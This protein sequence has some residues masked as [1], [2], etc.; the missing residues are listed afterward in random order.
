[1]SKIANITIFDTGYGEYTNSGTQWNQANGGS[2]ITLKSATINFSIG[3]SLNTNVP[4]GKWNSSDLFEYYNSPKIAVPTPT[5]R[6]SGVLDSK[7][8]DEASKVYALIEMVRSKGY[9]ILYYNDTDSARESKQL[10]YQLTKSGIGDTSVG[11]EH[12]DVGS[13]F[14]TYERTY[15]HIHVRFS[16]A[17]TIRQIPNSKLFHYTL[18]FV[19]IK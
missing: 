13:N 8:S 18:S 9:K 1:M 19:I 15:P 2:P 14:S 11:T 3:T 10:I 12:I 7:D 6:I 4:L 5:I 17:Q 16:G